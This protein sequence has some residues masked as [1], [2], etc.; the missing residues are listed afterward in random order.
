M[1]AYPKSEE[2]DRNEKMEVYAK[3]GV[4]EYWLNDWRVTGGLV[5]RYMLDDTGEKYLLHDKIQGDGEINVIS[6]PN[7]TF[8]MSELM[9]NVGDDEIIE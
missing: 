3:V 8:H 4:Q 9:I 7:W 1:P 5:E 6:F 2:I